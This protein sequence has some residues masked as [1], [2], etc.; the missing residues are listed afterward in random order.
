MLSLLVRWLGQ[1]ARNMGGYDRALAM[2]MTKM[3]A[4]RVLSLTIVKDCS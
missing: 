2:L 4:C 1:E 3:H